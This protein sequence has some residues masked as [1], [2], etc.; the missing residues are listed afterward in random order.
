[1]RNIHFDLSSDDRATL[2]LH[3]GFELNMLRRATNNNNQ[4]N[5][6]PKPISFYQS[7]CRIYVAHLSVSPGFSFLYFILLVGDVSGAEQIN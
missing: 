1:M 6:M 5:D 7:L 2:F 4:I 3:R